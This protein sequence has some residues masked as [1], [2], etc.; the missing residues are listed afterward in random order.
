[1][2]N[3]NRLPDFEKLLVSKGDKWVGERG[4]LGVWDGNVLKLGWD[5]GCTTIN[6]I[7]FIDLFKNI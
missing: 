7:K 3:R 5:N 1:M 2:Q 6:I 4:G